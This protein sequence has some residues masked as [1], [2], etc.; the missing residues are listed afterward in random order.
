MT[1]N[2]MHLRQLGTQL[3]VALL[4]N[5]WVLTTAE[6]CTGGWVAETV[7]SI[8]G[9]SK[10]FERGFV[11]YSDLAK[12]EM[13]GVKAATLEQQGAVSEQAAQEMAEGAIKHSAANVAVAITGIAG[14]EGGTPQ[15]PVGTVWIAWAG[16]NLSTHAQCYQLQGNRY[17]IR[18][19]STL[20]ALEG[21]LRLCAQ[22]KP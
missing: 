6:S 1:R 13:L 3:G 11:T 12:R 7:T 10:W 16:K 22:Q 14:P 17:T 18:L 2:P 4:T 20:H 8:A 15:K 19:Q 9:S 5:Q 21:L